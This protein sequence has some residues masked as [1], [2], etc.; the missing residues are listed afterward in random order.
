[1]KTLLTVMLTQN[2]ISLAYLILICCLEVPGG[3]PFVLMFNL[4]VELALTFH[5]RLATGSH[6][7]I[8]YDLFELGKTSTTNM[9]VRLHLQEYWWPC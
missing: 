7:H 8:W 9:A 1:M 5:E 4:P 6:F 3:M 2:K